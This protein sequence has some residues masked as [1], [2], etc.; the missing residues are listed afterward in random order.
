MHPIVHNS[1]IYNSQ[2]M[3]TTQMSF[4]REMNKEEVLYITVTME[5]YSST[6]KEW[7]S[8]PCNNVVDLETITVSEVNQTEKD[9]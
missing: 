6:K 5:Y 3:E 4:N 2:D 1:T 7:N 8:A 9:R